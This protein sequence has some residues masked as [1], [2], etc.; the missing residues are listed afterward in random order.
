MSIIIGID[1]A[2]I[3]FLSYEFFL[4]KL[5]YLCP[6][7]SILFLVLRYL[8]RSAVLKLRM[9]FFSAACFFNL[10]Y[11]MMNIKRS[12][13]VELHTTSHHQ[14]WVISYRNCTIYKLNISSRQKMNVNKYFVSK[15]KYYIFILS[16]LH[17]LQY[18]LYRTCM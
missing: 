12:W 15:C 1:I 18:L 6:V 4:W 17:V 11:T 2:N 10:Q 5:E 9:S 14:L 16:V 13:P 3:L 7:K 8:C